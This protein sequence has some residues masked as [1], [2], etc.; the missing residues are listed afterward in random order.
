MNTDIT[1]KYFGSQDPYYGVL[2]SDQYRDG[3]SSREF[4]QSGQAHVDR[5]MPLLQQ[6]FAL[7]TPIRFRR[8]LDF[9]CGVGRVALPLA[10][11]CDEVLGVDISG[12][13]LREAHRNARRMGIT[14]AT[15]VP[16]DDALSTCSGT[17]DFVH[18][19]IVLQHI[20]PPRGCQLIN[21]LARCL[22]PNGIGALQLTYERDALPHVELAYCICT[23][24]HIFSRLLNIIVL[25]RPSNQPLAEMNEYGLGDVVKLLFNQGCG[26][27]FLE[28][29]DTDGKWY[30][31]RGVFLFF[32]KSPVSNW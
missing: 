21:A 30:K 27:V 7:P 22:E 18:S 28:P 16:S 13:M 17:F 29:S 5:L 10:C 20:R 9:G 12:A 3:A 1:W 14:N 31:T 15:F 4:W 6:L 24:M 19:Y 32:R 2:T 26:R 11:A 25:N 23:K 8:A